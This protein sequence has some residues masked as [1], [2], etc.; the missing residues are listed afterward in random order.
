MNEVALRADKLSLHQGLLEQSVHKLFPR[1]NVLSNVRKGANIKNEETGSFLELDV[2]IPS[3]HICFEYQDAYHYTLTW[4]S[5]IPLSLIKERDRKKIEGVLKKGDTLV[6]VPCWW[7][8]SEDSLAETIHFQRPDLLPTR[9]PT[10]PIPLNPIKGFFDDS[11]IPVIG[12]LMLASFPRNHFHLA[13]SPQNPWWMGE[14]YD[15]IRCCWVYQHKKLYS[16]FSADL[17]IPLSFIAS[18]PPSL[19]D[20]ELWFGRGMFQ[21]SQRLIWLEAGVVEWLSMRYAV[22]DDPSNKLSDSPFEERYASLLD[23]IPSSHTFII[24]AM[25]ILCKHNKNMNKMLQSI[26]NDGGEESFYG[27]LSHLTRR[28]GLTTCLNL[29]HRGGTEKR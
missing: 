6:V 26:L 2:W 16:R 4:D 11:Y 27:G 20:G 25:R 17:Q 19:L 14:K 5:N 15:G 12:K 13:L 7:D 10:L 22:F 24:P 1:T 21:D 18:F 9:L 29:R 8:G 3:L 28:E 23:A